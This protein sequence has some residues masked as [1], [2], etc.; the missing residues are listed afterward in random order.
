MNSFLLMATVLTLAACTP[1]VPPQQPQ[2]AQALTKATVTVIPLQAAAPCTGAFIQHDLPFANGARIREM[3]TYASNGSGLAIADLDNDNDL[4]LIF[5]SIDGPSAVLWNEGT[6]QFTEQELDDVNT[7]AASSV[8]VDGDGN[9]DLVFT[10][11]T[12]G[13]SYWRNTGNRN[14]AQAKLHNVEAFAYSLAWGDLN[15][16]GQLDLV[17]GSYKAELEREGVDPSAIADRS[18][19]F[20]Y[21]RAGNSFVPH[22]LAT[23][24]QALSIGLVDL[25]RDGRNDIWVANDFVEPDDIWLRQSDQWVKAAPFAT[26]SH[27]TMSIDWADLN[28]DGGLA[29]FTTDMNPYDISIENMARWLP[30]TAATQQHHEWNDPQIM[31]NVLQVRDASG[32]WQNEAP[33]RGIDATGWSWAGRFG[34]LDNDGWLDLYVVNGMIA[35]N[36]FGHLPNDELSE[37]N[38]AF[39][40]KGDG[41]FALA[42]EWHL[43]ATASGRGMAMA[44]LDNDG[45]LD[46]AVNDLRSSSQ[47]FEN[48]LCGGSSLQVE[49]RW[50]GSTNAHAIGAWAELHT[51]QGTQRRDV[52]ANSGYLTGD[53]SRVHFGFRPAAV[54]QQLV[55]HWPDGATTR[56]EQINPNQLIMVTR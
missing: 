36:L 53:A 9:L 6:L 7:R 3:R 23:S 39:K 21:E 38:R 43:N 24:A 32:T 37:E 28:N 19:V 1:A 10:H 31:Q 18:G 47:V 20:Y 25:D 50:P 2:P 49:L 34:D 42:H 46:I 48:R 27:S 11:R 44:D 40:N 13:I 41:T 15:G 16:D 5:A 12:G 30:M 14:F 51:D 22:R 33:A 52:R 29:L 8:D 45:D 4:D 56:V 26:T 54:L 55:V 35:K 17:T